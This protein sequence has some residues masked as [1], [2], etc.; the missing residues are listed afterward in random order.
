MALEIVTRIAALQLSI[1]MLLG[2]YAVCAQTVSTPLNSA[3]PKAT[4]NAARPNITLPP[5]KAEPVR[6]VHFETAPIIDGRL[7]DTAWQQAAVLKDFYQIQPGENIAPSQSTNDGLN[8]NGFSPF[9]N[10]LE[11]GFGATVARS[12]S[13][14]LTYSS[15]VSNE[16]TEVKFHRARCC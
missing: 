1:F 12:S 3:S 2:V 16:A 10:Q 13:R 6:I 5:E 15:V 7:D 11:P 9:T 8:R 14:C 4:T